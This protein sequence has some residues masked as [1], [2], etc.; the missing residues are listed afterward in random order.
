MEKLQLNLNGRIIVLITKETCDYDV[1]F[2]ARAWNLNVKTIDK[3]AVKEGIT[4]FS[5]GDFHCKRVSDKR[6]NNKN[7]KSIQQ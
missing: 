4:S 6:D 1:C 2:K 5:K 7:N 3:E